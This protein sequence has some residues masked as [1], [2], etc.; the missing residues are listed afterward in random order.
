MKKNLIIFVTI[1]NLMS[2][3][4]VSSAYAFVDP[5]SLT[6]IFGA[7]FLTA[8]TGTEIVKQ[9]KAVPVSA[10]DKDQN[11]TQVQEKTDKVTETQTKTNLVPNGS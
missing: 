3:G 1:L 9:E 4:T 10:Q 5:V 6:V 7:T 11:A 2:I 8:V